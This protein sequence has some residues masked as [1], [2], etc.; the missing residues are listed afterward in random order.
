MIVMDKKQELINKIFEDYG[1]QIEELMDEDLT[2]IANHQEYYLILHPKV[3]VE[4]LARDY[5]ERFQEQLED[6]AYQL[7][8]GGQDGI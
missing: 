6:I 3:S 8:T 2:E 5:V 1:E 4:L 7:I